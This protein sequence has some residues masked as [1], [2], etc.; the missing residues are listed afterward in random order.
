[1]AMKKTHLINIFYSI[2]LIVSI[3]IVNTSLS[4]NKPTNP[5]RFTTLNSSFI[6]II[7]FGNYR[8]ISSFLWTKTLLDA[9]TEHVKDNK[10]SWLFYRFKL[11]SDLDPTFYE[12]YLQ[13]GI[14]L[15]IIKDDIWGAEEIFL[16]GLKHFKNDYKLLYYTAF[17]YHFELKDY[18]NSLIYYRR[19]QQLPESNTMTILPKLIEQA[20]KK[21]TPINIR[22]ITLQRE[23][24]SSRDEKVKEAILKKIDEIKKGKQ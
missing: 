20:Q 13:G 5:E 12:N 16:K 24:H 23:Y 7:S 18:K 6:K 22:L 21:S 2:I 1:M 15:S 14:Y 4:F 11:I 10:K 17:N 8:F 3:M 9:D 19:L